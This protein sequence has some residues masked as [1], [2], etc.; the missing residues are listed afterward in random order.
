[1]AMKYDQLPEHLKI[2][3]DVHLAEND[4]AK[5]PAP[6]IPPRLPEKPC[7]QSGRRKTKAEM[8]F[9]AILAAWRHKGLIRQWLEQAVTLRFSD[10]TSYRPDYTAITHQGEIWHIEV[11]GGYRGWGWEQ[12]YERFRRARDV[13]QCPGVRLVL[14]TKSKNGWKIEGVDT[15]ISL[16][17]GEY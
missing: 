8:A 5:L 9:A 3:V 17:P 7:R 11:K 15:E 16:K 10:G 1:M 2:L 12:G 6:A 4:A 14:A 13:F